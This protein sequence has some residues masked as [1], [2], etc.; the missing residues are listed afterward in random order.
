MFGVFAEVTTIGI[1]CIQYAIKNETDPMSGAEKKKQ[2]VDTVMKEVTDPGGIEIKNKLVLKFLP[3]LI[4]PIIDYVVW[5]LKQT[6]FFG[7][8]TG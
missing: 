5:G 4:P 1:A 3:Q 6:G 7:K 2:V 8:S